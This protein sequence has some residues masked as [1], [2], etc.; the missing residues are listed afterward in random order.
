MESVLLEV[1]RAVRGLG[2]SEDCNPVLLRIR[3]KTSLE[4]EPLEVYLANPLRFP[5]YPHACFQ[6]RTRS[7]ISGTEY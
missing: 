3:C 5:C 4:R 2:V 6:Y 1:F 7:R